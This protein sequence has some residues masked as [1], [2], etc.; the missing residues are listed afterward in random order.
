M[1]AIQRC[2]ATM[3]VPVSTAVQT[4][5]PVVLEPLFLQE[6][7]RSFATQVLPVTAGVVIALAG[8]ALVGRDPAVSDLAAGR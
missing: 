8:V 4:F 2:A 5:L 7:Y 6:R 3:V 1:S